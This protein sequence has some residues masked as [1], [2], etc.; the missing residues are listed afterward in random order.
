MI[1]G[2]RTEGLLRRYPSFIRTVDSHTA[3]EATR[4]IVSGLPPVPGKTMLEK[5]NAFRTRFDAVRLRLT[6]EPRGSRDLL[7]ALLTD[8]VSTGSDF[9][10]IYMD[11]RRYPFL[12]GHATIGAVSTAI[13][14]EWIQAHGPETWV[15]VDTPSGPMTAR[16]RIDSGK[17]RAV[18]IRMVPSFV[19]ELDQPLSVPGTGTLHV[20]TVCVGG[21]FVMVSAEQIDLSMDA[22]DRH[23]WIELGMRVIDEANRQLTVA[24]PLREEVK[25]VDVVEFYA[26]MGRRR[27]RSIVIYGE[28]H[29]DRSPCG[30]GTAAKLTLLHHRGELSTGEDFI[31]EGPLGTTFTARIVEKTVVG[32]LPAVTVEIEGRAHIT[33]VHSFLIDPEDPLPEGFLL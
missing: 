2:P 25:S 22:P 31:N 9:G 3:G 6:R 7:A 12:C 8:P 28:R 16:A 30:T 4:L 24:H 5:L 26:P 10:L 32:G 19:Y 13:E 20:D 23:R 11:A 21:F 15:T 1:T 18:A 29:M 14:S 17:P 27:G 33:G